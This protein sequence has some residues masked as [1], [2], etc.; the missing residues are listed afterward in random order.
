L[1]ILA[2]LSGN[3]WWT[4]DFRR[5]VKG[6]ISFGSVNQDTIEVEGTVS[7]RLRLVGE[8]LIHETDPWIFATMGTEGTLRWS[9]GF[10]SLLHGSLCTKFP[11]TSAVAEEALTVEKC[12]DRPLFRRRSYNLSKKFSELFQDFKNFD[13]NNDD[14]LNESEF[15]SH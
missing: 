12:H 10:T 9:N 11:E 7:G 4:A 14:I 8:K 3:S 2:G 6:K 13:S 1:H 15:L 5:Q